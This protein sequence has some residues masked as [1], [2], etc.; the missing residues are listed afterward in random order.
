MRKNL[1]EEGIN[2]APYNSA[3]T[4]VFI[5]GGG[6]GGHLFPGI[7][8]AEVLRDQGCEVIFVCRGNDFERRA[9]AHAG[10]PLKTVWIE[11]LKGRGLKNKLVTFF[12]LPVA[13]L[14]SLW[15]M[16]RYR[17]KVVIGLGS[18]SAGPVIIAAWMTRRPAALMEQNAV[19][20]F[21]NR[22]CRH[23]A[24]KIFLSFGKS[25]RFFDE[26]KCVLSGNPVRASFF[27]GLKEPARRHDKFTVLILGGSQG[28]HAVNELVAQSLQHLVEKEHVRYIHQSG[29]YD[30]ETLREAYARYGVEAEVEAF[31]DDVAPLYQAADF[32]ICRAGATTIAELT[33]LG[34][35]AYFIPFPQAADNHQEKNAMV[36]VNAGAALMG[37]ESELAGRDLAKVVNKM[38]E[39]DSPLRAM[40]QA[41]LALG[42]PD[43]ARDVA[44]GCLGLIKKP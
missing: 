30:V 41:A 10:F 9:L 27:A 39:P 16:L 4:K 28:A 38:R 32:I 44:S 43:A 1:S 34:K 13:G 14:Q 7:A 37:R 2:V 23:F 35:A 18:Y 12:K 29:A 24:S 8:V 20:G 15:L 19:P 36:L 21:T 42:R 22:Q 33:A 11:G 17:P 40:E 26:S 5:T 25:A 3:P 6:T 31:F